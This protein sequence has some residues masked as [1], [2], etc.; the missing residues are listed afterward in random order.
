MVW[1]GNILCGKFFIYGIWVWE[2]ELSVCI[3]YV[4]VIVVWGVV[5]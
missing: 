3:R 5:V 4:I 2:V 1:V